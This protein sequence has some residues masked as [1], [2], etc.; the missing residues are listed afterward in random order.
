MVNDNVVPG[1]GA[2]IRNAY[3]PSGPVT[4]G[5]APAW[6]APALSFACAARSASGFSVTGS[7]SEIV[8]EANGCAAP[9]SASKMM[10]LVP[11]RTPAGVLADIAMPSA[12]IDAVLT[13]ECP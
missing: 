5:F 3:A 1:A 11:T 7:T 9:R 12:P 4:N 10:L 8:A 6:F 13:Y 2:A